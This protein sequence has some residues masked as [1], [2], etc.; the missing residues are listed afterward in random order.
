MEKPEFRLKRPKIVFAMACCFIVAAPIN[1]AIPLRIQGLQDWYLPIRWL[2]LL[3]AYDLDAKLAISLMP[4]A[5]ACL[6]FQR[7]T[8]WFFAIALLFGISLDNTYAYFTRDD[9]IYPFAMPLI[10]NAAA[11]WIFSYFRFPYLDRRDRLFGGI[12][13]RYPAQ[14][15]AHIESLGYQA[16]TKDI[17]KS[18][19]FLMTGKNPQPKP[20]TIVRLEI[21]GESLNGLVVRQTEN[22]FAV[23][24]VQ[25][26]PRRISS[27]QL[28]RMMEK[29]APGNSKA[30]AA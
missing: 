11:I 26:R 27:R 2:Q 17:S 30:N 23:Q 10:I 25:S 24:F 28:K 9:L 14:L 16:M 20:G 7:K 13:H 6:F 4:V 15:S 1:L 18:G 21:M 29:A 12:A 3:V 8:S 19:C 22:G 5:G